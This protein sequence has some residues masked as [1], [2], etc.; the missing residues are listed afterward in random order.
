M[1]QYT[2]TTLAAIATTKAKASND[3]LARRLRSTRLSSSPNRYPSPGKRA[4]TENTNTSNIPSSPSQN[5]RYTRASRFASSGR[6]TTGANVPRSST[7]QLTRQYGSI[8][9]NRNDQPLRTSK[10]HPS[11]VNNREMELVKGISDQL[12][13][14]LNEPAL[15]A[16]LDLLKRGEH[17]DA[18]VAVVTSLAQHSR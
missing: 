1:A 11:T 2:S 16:I 3:S 7:Q 10:N 9:N 4:T 8:H 18:I 17:P 5:D 13:T 15:E 6:N 14:G 12:E